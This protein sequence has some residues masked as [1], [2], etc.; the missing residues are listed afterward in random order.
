M[1]NFIWLDSALYPEYQK[2]YCTIFADRADTKF[3]VAE[4]TKKYEFKK[5]IVNAQIKVSADT[6]FNLWCNEKWVG[7]GPVAAGGDYGNTLPMPKY[8]FNEYT[9]NPDS[10]CIE[11]FARVYLSPDVMTD[12]SCGKGGFILR[13]DITFD[14]GTSETVRTDESWKARLNRGY[15]ST[16][17]LDNTITPDE[18]TDAKITQ[19]VWN[20]TSAPIPMLSETYIPDENGI[21]EIE[22][23]ANKTYVGDIIFDKIYSGHVCLN[24]DTDSLCEILIETY[25][26]PGHI[27]SRE[28]IITDKPLKYR[29]L[30]MQSLGGYT[31][32]VKT[33]GK[34]YIL[35]IGQIFTCYPVTQ[36]GSFHCSDEILNKIYEVGKHTLKICRQTLHLDSPLH[37]ETLGCTGDY[38]IESL[39]NYFI[40]GDARLTRLDIIRTADWI[41]MSGGFMFHTSYSL[42]WVGMM[43]DYYMFTADKSVFDD[44]DESIKILLERFNGY[45]GDTGVI[46]NPPNYMF[47]DWGDIDGFSMHHPPKALGQT[48]LNAFYYYALTSA[49]KIYKIKGDLKQ[50]EIYASRAASLKENFR[51]FF[52][53]ERGLYFDGFNTPTGSNQ[54]MPENTDKR[55]YLRHCNILAVLYGLCDNPVPIMEKVMTEEFPFMVQPYFMHYLLEALTVSGLFEKYGLAEIRK[56]QGQIE[57]CDKGMKEGWGAFHGDYSH[58]WGSTPTYQLPY[59]MLGFE[60]LEAGYKKI[61][62]SPTLLG[63]KSAE[64]KIPT[65]FGYIECKM[66]KSEKPEI[67]VPSEI[68][69][70]I[71]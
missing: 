33:S 1:K 3:C 39:M 34:A 51:Q 23:G 40:Y 14:D 71:K 54:W 9:V 47:I 10:E 7:I 55:Y 60:I 13:C 45:V 25:E 64:I 68:E 43:Y 37:Q 66:N 4:F 50:S 5:K 2:T 12:Y 6:K 36:E 11:F 8:Y 63:L 22:V 30:R 70:V 24:I 46:E 16:C 20:L 58:A 69:A 67:K 48:S 61:A 29:G 38:A 59:K 53:A 41:K 32:T 31:L 28:K 15:K 44:T 19:S 27:V 62:L 56:W 26:I 52:D 18:W 65:P 49:A 17:E 21:T 57:E 42:I 35:E